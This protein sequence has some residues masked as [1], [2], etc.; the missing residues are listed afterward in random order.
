MPIITS[1]LAVAAAAVAVAVAST[2]ELSVAAKCSV[3]CRAS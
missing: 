2:A 1:G 3:S